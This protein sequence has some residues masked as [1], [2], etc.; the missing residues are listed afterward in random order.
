MSMLTSY[1]DTLYGIQGRVLLLGSLVAG[2]LLIAL[3]TGSGIASESSPDNGQDNGQIN[4]QIN[5]Q[6]GWQDD[7]QDT[8]WTEKV[9]T[10]PVDQ[11][12]YTGSLDRD[13]LLELIAA[14]DHLFNAR[15]TSLDGVGRPQATQAIVPTRR[16]H[17]PRS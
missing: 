3:T 17:A 9:L 10:R 7:W 6:D 5:R 12:R 1:R 14:G 16:K 13:R 8:P 4:R 11:E 2:S 15:F